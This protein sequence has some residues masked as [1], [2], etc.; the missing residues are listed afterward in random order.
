MQVPPAMTSRNRTAPTHPIGWVWMV[1]YL[2]LVTDAR[3]AKPTELAFSPVESAAPAGA[4]LLR[5]PSFESVPGPMQGEGLMPS[6]WTILAVTPDTYSIDGSFGLP[7][8]A[9]GNFA[10]VVA[11]DGIRWVAAWGTSTS[12][13]FGQQLSSPLLPNQSYQ[14]SG[15][16]HRAIRSDL[17]N[18]GTYEILLAPN[19]PTPQN[20]VVLGQFAPAVNP[21]WEPRSLTFAAPPDSTSRPWLVFRPVPTGTVLSTYPG[22]DLLGLQPRTCDDEICNGVDDDCDGQIDEDFFVLRFDPDEPEPVPAHAGDPCLFGSGP[23]A[24]PGTLE[25]SAKGL[26][27]RC[28]PE[29]GEIPV[30][31]PEGPYGTTS[32][33]NLLDDDCDGLFDEEELNCRGP[34]ICDG[35]D[36]NF[37]GVVDE[38]WPNLGQ[39]CEVGLGDCR[40]DGVFL[41]NP[42]GITVS[43]SAQPLPADVEGP[44]ESWRCTDGRDNDCDGVI[45]LDDPDCQS[46]EVCDGEDNDGDGLVDE[47]FQHLGSTCINGVGPCGRL[48][49]YVCTPDGSG[50][51]CDTPPGRKE[52]ER[53]PCEC[54]D[55]VDNDCDGLTDE[56]DPDCA[57]EALSVRA[58]LPT[59]CRSPIG[60]CS[61]RHRVDWVTQNAGPGLLEIAEFV[62]LDEN[63]HGL[64]VSALPVHRGDEVRI[65]SRTAAALVRLESYAFSMDLDQVGDNFESCLLGPGS[66]V[67]GQCEFVDSD[68]DRDV[69]LMDIAAMQNRFGENVTIH[70]VVA[71]RPVLRV[72][73]RDADEKATAFASPVPHVKVWSPDETVV[74]LS[75]G[76]RVRVEIALPN[77]SVAT[78]ELFIDG[79]AVFPAMGLIPGVAFPGGPFYG[80]VSLPNN[81][82]A[83]ICD[84]MVDSAD[85]ESPSA[86]SLVMYVE[87]MCCGGHRFVIRGRP[88]PG[89]Y[90][91]PPPASCAGPDTSDDGVAHGFEVRLL[92]PLDGEVDPAPPTS[93]VGLACHGVAL[94][95]PFPSSDAVVRLNGILFPLNPPVVTLGDGVFTA[96]KYE[97]SFNALLPETDLFDAVVLGNPSV[98]TLDPGGNKLI[99]EVNDPQL[100]ATFDV[101]SMAVGPIL[102]PSAANSV[103][104]GA[105]EPVE[106]GFCVVAS[107]DA[108]TTI[109]EEAMKQ[110]VAPRMVQRIQNAVT[111]MQ[112]TQATIP[113]DACDVEVGIL[114][115]D[116][117]PFGFSMSVD[118]FTYSVTLRDGQLDASAASGPIHAQGSIRGR[119]Q[120]DL[121]DECLIRVT[122]SVG[123]SLDIAVVTLSTTV[124][125]RDVLTQT[126]TP[127]L[128]LNDDDVQITVEDVD[129]IIECWFGDLLNI[130][131]PGVIEELVSELVKAKLQDFVD[132]L[133][134]LELLGNS[135]IIAPMSGLNFD[136]VE[137]DQ[138]G[139]RFEFDLTEA[140]ISEDGVSVGFRTQF[141]PTR[142]DPEVEGLPGIPDTIAELPLPPLP[143][144]PAQG[145]AALI[146]DDA[147]NQLFEALTRNGIIKTRYEDQRRLGDL[148]PPDCA[149]LPAGVY[150]F[151]EGFKG[152]DCATLPDVT[153][154]FA[155]TV[156]AGLRNSANLSEESLLLL[157]GR[158]DVPPKL[159]VWD[160]DADSLTL[161]VR[162][163]QAFVGVVADRDGDGEFTEDYTTVPSCLAGN[164][165]SQTECAIWGACFD[166]NFQGQFTLTAGED[167]AYTLTFALVDA[168]LSSATGCSG[169]VVIPG[170]YETLEAIFEGLVFDQIQTLVDNNVPPLTLQGLD[171]GGVM[172]LEEL[173]LLTHGNEFDAS[174]EDCFGLTAE[175][176]PS[177]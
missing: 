138:L 41:C 60:D 44:P 153:E 169:G 10:G 117:V 21:Q 51:Q 113:T 104:A 54:G 177:D 90:P 106:H 57:D 29:P 30:P 105:G 56:L 156:A 112:G 79:V 173:R 172:T 131:G 91:D 11:R 71:P 78:L 89:A 146:A 26:E 150:G 137:I 139:V 108:I 62:A 144:P 33:I 96:D 66:P 132:E 7:P 19:P 43:C 102:T 92:N 63:G 77:V 98:G 103:A 168:N 13:V 14:L 27:L 166:V 159:L 120:I 31:N 81:C 69:D 76:D 170:A 142:I 127:V 129:P 109:V 140:E 94:D 151:C 70:N 175:P 18:P 42:T 80:S 155:C 34:E 115:D 25:C 126:V 160:A 135:N 36:N 35:A 121:F 174:F 118:E 67:S 133:D 107:A 95:S 1:P 55:H 15:W 52:P 128:I 116:P 45:D 163:S 124:T 48:G 111:A 161:Y 53:L 130:V 152:T 50:V 119:C 37:N 134:V 6:D 176:V 97:Y 171:F 82:V 47:G 100:N 125:E 74:S 84:L 114:V 40:Q 28:V 20:A 32:C 158:V 99:A 93:V 86:N 61:S 145:L 46:D 165:A 141:V 110:R 123:L 154:E 157:H 136:P 4:N 16:V 58:S 75:D 65:T 88:Q 23:C 22:L 68:C 83:E 164:P 143:A 101:V 167:G 147:V 85:I 59:I 8:S 12:E 64:S 149:V 72:T 39:P 3:A 148:L 24:S 38:H 162:L 17:A 87:G 49:Q 122:I 9:F 5:N 2:L 73:A